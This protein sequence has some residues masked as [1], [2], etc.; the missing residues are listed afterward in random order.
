MVDQM[1]ISFY[2]TVKINDVF[3]KQGWP[4]DEVNKS[5]LYHRFLQTYIQLDS[6]ERD[7]FIKLSAM[8]RWV[9]FSEY[10]QLIVPLM[11][12]AVQKYYGKKTQDVWIYPIKKAEHLGTIKSSDLVAYLCKAVQ[13]QHS[14]IL[15]KRKFHVLGSFDLVQEKKQK[16][17]DR[18][19]LILDDFIGSGKYVS[20]VID[21][22][23]QNGIPSSSIVVC[24]LFV[25]ENG[26]KQVSNTGCRIEYIEQAQNILSS[27]SPQEKELLKQIED[28]LGVEEEFRLGFGGSANL[29]TLIRTP[30]NS[31][32]LFWLDKGRSHTAPFPR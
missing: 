23:S 28:T 16:F 1:G 12:Q 4:I 7:L 13:L 5:S 24:S 32:P 30:N 3:S 19:L 2:D 8:Y 6:T 21:E 17:K 15:Y 18:P 14:D 27:I 20:D 29:I 9:S 26:L 31:L 25:S 10:Q 22:L 11:E